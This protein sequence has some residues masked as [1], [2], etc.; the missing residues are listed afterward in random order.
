ML[1][2][3]YV[4]T[5][6]ADYR[7][8]NVDSPTDILLVVARAVAVVCALFLLL[9]VERAECAGATPRR[10]LASFWN[11]VNLVSYVGVLA[12]VAFDTVD[13]LAHVRD[14]VVAVL[15]V[16]LWMNLL[17]FLQVSSQ[18]GLLVAMM[19]HMIK[20]VYRFLLL[21]AVFLLGYSGAF[22]VLLR[23]RPGYD[24][25][26]NA[27]I[28]VF[29]MLFGALDYSV[30]SADSL[31]GW[32]WLV[33][34]TLLLSHLVT[35][36]VMLLNI[37]IAMMTATFEDVWDAAEAEALLIRARAIVRIEKALS[38]RERETIWRMLLSAADLREWESLLAKAPP[39]PSLIG[40][41]SKLRCWFKATGAA[42]VRLGKRVA[43][44]LSF[45]WFARPTTS[46]LRRVMD[47]FAA[48]RMAP[49]EDGVR[50]EESVG[51]A[52]RSDVAAETSQRVVELQ[53][54][55]AELTRLIAEMQRQLS[56]ER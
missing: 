11:W 38:D 10:Y 28:T 24:S 50:F 40:N 1:L 53:E 14:G 31:R 44:G 52:R 43:N 20:D 8:L 48:K 23:G 21:Y 22:Y 34:N 46:K 51:L 33:G 36:V 13:S 2:A 55:V 54:Q 6:A 17:Q 19:T 15:H 29:L 7:P 39:E 45:P 42:L 16:S 25:F 5:V 9:S 12:S 26:V 37:L 27:F 3:F 49:L 4:P 41:L 30:F 32:S 56:S 47:L 35:V 18:S